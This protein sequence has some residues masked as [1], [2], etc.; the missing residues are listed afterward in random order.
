MEKAKSLKAKN[1]V[2]LLGALTADAVLFALAS[3]FEQLHFKTSWEILITARSLLALLLP[4]VLLLLGS[5]LPSFVKDILV[6]W[7]IKHVLPGHRAFEQKTLTDPRIDQ[8]RLRKNVGAF[9]TDPGEQNTTWYRLFKKVE[10]EI[11]IDH[12]HGQFL[13]LRD[14]AAISAML[15]PG[16]AIAWLFGSLSNHEAQ[17]LAV[18]LAGQFILSAVSARFQGQGL[19]RSVLALH[20]AK[21][22]V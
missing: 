22:R 4:F 20:G 19:V 12:V 15:L 10:T 5:L 9:P 14:L 2:F 17:V 21:R 16:C 1:R 8:V 18:I 7:R 11:S 6:F 13:L 3:V